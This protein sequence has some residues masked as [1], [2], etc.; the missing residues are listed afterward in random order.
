M[1]N[2]PDKYKKLISKGINS[3]SN[4]PDLNDMTD[5]GSFPLKPWTAKKT[6]GTIKMVND[7]NIKDEE[8]FVGKFEQL[9]K[10]G[11]VDL[12][13]QVYEHQIKYFKKYKYDIDTIFKYTYCCI[14]VNSL[15]GYS[16]EKVFDRWAK[17]N[18]IKI[19]YPPAILDQKYHTDR[20]ELNK[21]NTI[22]SFISIKPNSFSNN[23]IQYTD[24]FCAL[25][26]LSSIT[27]IEWKIYFRNNVGFS[28]ITRDSLSKREKDKIKENGFKYSKFEKIELESIINSM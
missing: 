17:N 18:K 6:V 1:N 10:I 11:L 15:K 20:L 25:E 24:V 8:S 2:L 23:Y 19:K 27:N 22:K 4:L 5:R 21:N 14:V 7:Y 12:T 26:L 3:S 9:S 16:T 13:N 28:I